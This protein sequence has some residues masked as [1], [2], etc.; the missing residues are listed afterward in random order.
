MEFIPLMI[1]MIFYAFV[2]LTC[3][4][5]GVLFISDIFNLILFSLRKKPF[6]HDIIWM[7]SVV[8]DHHVIRNCY[9]VINLIDDHGYTIKYKEFD[10]IL[11]IKISKERM[12]RLIELQ[13]ASYRFKIFRPRVYFKL[14]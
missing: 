10:E 2:F 9:G 12:K 6:Y 11:T 13:K 5:L 14:I 4:I 1:S 3:V 7:R 8:V